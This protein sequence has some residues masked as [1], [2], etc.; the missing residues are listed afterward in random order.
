MAPVLDSI[1]VIE[2]TE[3]LAGPYCAMLLGDF[4]ADVI[5]VER[6]QTGDQ[7]RSWGPP[8]VGSESAYFLATN[9]NKRSLSLDY[10]QPLGGAILHRLL[11]TA[12]VF[13]INQRNL[14]SLEQRGLDAK[15]D[16]RTVSAAG[17]LRHLRLWTLGAQVGI[18]GLRHHRA[19]PGRDHEL[20]RRAGR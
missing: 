1:R 12:D 13:L 8:F 18:A 3:A 14:A 5:K 20:Y 15:D 11:S 17:L 4:G 9:R 19:G 16:L 7:S 10:D 2:L 6:R